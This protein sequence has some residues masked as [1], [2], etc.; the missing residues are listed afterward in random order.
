MQKFISKHTLL[1]VVW[2][3]GGS[4]DLQRR[5]DLG[6]W[7]AAVTTVAVPAAC[8]REAGGEGEG[9]GRG[10]E[11]RSLLDFEVDIS[12]GEW[13]PVENKVPQKSPTPGNEPY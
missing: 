7:V 4:L 5:E 6:S 13:V 1:C 12:D 2:A 11:D 9:G 8:R 3:F 10:A